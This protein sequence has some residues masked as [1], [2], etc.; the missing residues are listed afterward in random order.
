M[1]MTRKRF[2]AR[3]IAASAA[4]LFIPKEA[5]HADDGGTAP[6]IEGTWRFDNLPA[7]GGGAVSLQTFA[8]GGVFLENLVLKAAAATSRFPARTTS[9][10]VWAR[11]GPHVYLQT[12]EYF[13]RTT[14]DE[15]LRVNINQEVQVSGD[16]MTIGNSK[17]TRYNLDG[18]PHS[19]APCE[20]SNAVGVRL[21]AEAPS[22]P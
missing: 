1:T 19:H 20:L 13:V 10:G 18:T 9:Q 22:C 4:A 7:P 14:S 15:I 2:F 3:A 17:L 8:R 21:R 16:V 12:F 11:T 6:E 5:A